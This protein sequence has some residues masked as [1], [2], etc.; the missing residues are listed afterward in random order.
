MGIIE[1][2]TVKY[3]ETPT[4]SELNGPYTSLS[5]S[6]VDGDNM[7]DGSLRS[8]H[9]NTT[10]RINQSFFTNASSGSWSSNNTTFTRVD[11]SGGGQGLITINET[12]DTDS[13]VRV[14]WDLLIGQE[15]LVYVD[16]ATLLNNL[17]GFKIR[18]TLNS[19]AAYIDCAPG[20]YSFS[21]RS[22]S[23]L[24]SA[25]NF[26][27]IQWRSCSGSEIVFLSSG[28]V[29]DKVELLGAVGDATN[30]IDVERFNIMTIIG[31]Q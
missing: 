22:G 19:G 4:A 27:A 25:V 13:I 24:Q 7:K 9:F 20:V 1:K 21:S 12:L 6:F 30:T 29:I 5:T 16:D 2:K 23:T 3:G 18:I 26:K 10:T 31:R 17:Y 28:Q 14:Q 8:P 11:L 15:N